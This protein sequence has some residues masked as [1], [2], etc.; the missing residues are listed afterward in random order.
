MIQSV[1]GSTNIALRQIYKNAYEDRTLVIINANIVHW[2]TF[3]L[4]IWKGSKFTLIMDRIRN[5]HFIQ[6]WKVL[7]I[8]DSILKNISFQICKFKLKTSK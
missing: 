1:Y 4:Q 6:M 8:L 5:K 2:V 7:S 3:V